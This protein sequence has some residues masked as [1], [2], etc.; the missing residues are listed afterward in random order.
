MKFSDI[1]DFLKPAASIAASLIPGGSAVVEAVNLLLPDD[2]KLPENATGGQVVA[3]YEGLTPEQQSSL[4]EK[5][6]DLEI[7]KV[8]VDSDNYIAMCEADGQTTRPKIA[9]AMCQVLC[10]EILLFTV[11]CFVHPE[12]MDSTALWSIFA[13]LTATPTAVLIRYFGV[14][15]KEQG[16]R[17]GVQKPSL[18][19]N[20]FG[21]LAGK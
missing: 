6:I 2:K 8:E 15:V 17:L 3:A 18:L 9:W 11:W 12:E 5:E 20:L 10:A 7:R 16:N 13:A 19:G 14:L 1:L 4:R 21:K